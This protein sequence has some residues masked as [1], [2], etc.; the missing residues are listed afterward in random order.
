MKQVDIPLQ[1]SL[2]YL[3]DQDTAVPL[4]VLYYT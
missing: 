4:N 2:Q 3:I 1:N